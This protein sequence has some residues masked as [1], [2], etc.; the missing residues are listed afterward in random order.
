MFARQ[1]QLLSKTRVPIVAAI[2]QLATYTRSLKLQNALNG[3]ADNI[4][5]GKSLSDSLRLFPDVF[6]HSS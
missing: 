2:K 4:E 5:K 6:L 1:M 3:V